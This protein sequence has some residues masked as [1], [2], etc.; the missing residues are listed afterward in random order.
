MT[1]GTTT[2]AH[3]NAAGGGVPVLMDATHWLQVVSRG[4]SATTLAAGGHA[5]CLREPRARRGHVSDGQIRCRRV[6][7]YHQVERIVSAGVGREVA[8]MH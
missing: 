3:I 1:S 8:I 4:L 5:L 6:G 7:Q 2:A